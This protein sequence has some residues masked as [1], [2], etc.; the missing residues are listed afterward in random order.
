MAPR[1]PVLL[2]L[3]AAAAVAAMVTLNPGGAPTGVAAPAPLP[4]EAAPAPMPMAAPPGGAGAC[5]TSSSLHQSCSRCEGGSAGDGGVAAIGGLCREHCSRQ[6]TGY[7]GTG[8]QYVDGG[9][10]CRPCRASAPGA[11]AAGPA[12][13]AAP[14]VPAPAPPPIGGPPAPAAPPAA[15]PPPPAAESVAAAA[16][17]PT[18]STA[19]NTKPPLTTDWPV[20]FTPLRWLFFQEKVDFGK[21]MDPFF[22]VLQE[23]A[24]TSRLVE[25]GSVT[26]WGPGFP[27]WNN[28]ASLRDNIKAEHGS[29]DFFDVVF[30]CG[31]NPKFPTEMKGE[32]VVIGTR[33]HECR[34]SEPCPCVK[35]MNIVLKTR[36]C[37]LKTRNCVS[38]T[39][40]FAL[41]DEFVRAPLTL[42][43]VR[44]EGFVG[45]RQGR[46]LMMGLVSGAAG[47]G[48]FLAG[49][50]VQNEKSCIKQ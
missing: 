4:A 48:A 8:E 2:G 50:R 44:F 34:P 38:K 12:S 29:K 16:A 1:I 27:K 28:A 36:N 45:S 19:C 20:P 9:L 3:L 14:P 21:R 39:R 30:T 13:M 17:V 33:K 46:G 22:R 43:R 7:C 26:H 31:G 32:R 49:T 40:C 41:N 35:V 18:P 15:P 10:D 23:G 47:G 5:A 42:S 37:A 6:G 25:G 24:R 11:G